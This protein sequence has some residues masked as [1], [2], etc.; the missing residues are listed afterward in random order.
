MNDVAPDI[1]EKVTKQYD[2]AMKADK[3]AAELLNKVKNG[4]AT[5]ADASKYA[6]IAGDKLSKALTDNI[7]SD[8]LPDGKMYY[9]IAQRVL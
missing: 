7:S 6:E 9:N 5:Y 3:S 2:D 1:L 4:A 8:I